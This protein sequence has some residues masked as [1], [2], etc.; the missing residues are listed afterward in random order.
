MKQPPRW[1]TA[2]VVW[3]SIYPTITTVIWLLWPLIAA[4]PIPLKT[5]CIT[6]LVVPTVVYFVLPFMQKLLKNWLNS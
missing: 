5:L 2:I 3:L 6:L 1:K 4:F